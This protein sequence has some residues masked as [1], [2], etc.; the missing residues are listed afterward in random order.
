ALIVGPNV[1]IAEQLKDYFAYISSFYEIYGIV[2]TQP[3]PVSSVIRGDAADIYDLDN[4]DVIVTNIQQLNSIRNEWV[5][6]LP[7]NYFDIIIFDEGHHSAARSWQRIR[8]RF[9]KTKMVYLT[10]TPVRSD[11]KVTEGVRVYGYT[12]AEAITKGYVKR[13]KALEI[14][15][16]RVQ[17]GNNNESITIEGNDI[18]VF[19]ETD[20]GFRRNIVTLA[21]TRDSIVDVSI[22]ELQRMRELTSE[23]RLKIIAAA[24]NYEHC[25]E[26]AEAYK[27]RGMRVDYIHSE[28]HEDENRE[29]LSKLKNHELDVIVQ[30]RMLGEGFDH[31]Y[32]SVAAMF[33]VFGSITTYVQFIGRIMRAIVPN[34]PEHPLNTGTVVYHQGGFGPRRWDEFLRFCQGVYHFPK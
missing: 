6:E 16:Q 32:L 10:A 17:Y 4:S 27:K 5:L 34:D 2:Q 24:R 15:P 31:I 11:R 26:V 18:R 3:F 22:Q 1:I 23:P 20:A 13:I 19:G 8:Q 28:E 12:V 14:K 9:P 30:V 21:T 33:G 7:Q 25:F 29:V